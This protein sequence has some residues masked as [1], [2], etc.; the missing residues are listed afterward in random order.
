[1]EKNHIERMVSKIKNRKC[2]VHQKKAT[3]EIHNGGVI[4]QNYCC[5]DFY[6]ELQK[7]FQEELDSSIKLF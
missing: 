5:S 6:E 4:I 2:S 1:M 3:F 7:R